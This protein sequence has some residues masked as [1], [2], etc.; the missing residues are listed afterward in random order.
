[1][2]VKHISKFDYDRQSSV[3]YNEDKLSYYL[4]LNLNYLT[5]FAIIP[6]SRFIPIFI[7]TISVAYIRRQNLYHYYSECNFLYP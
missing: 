4:H 3:G 7:E 2:Y 6:L 5:S 1:M